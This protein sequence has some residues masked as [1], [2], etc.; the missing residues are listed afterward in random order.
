MKKYKYLQAFA[1]TFMHVAGHNW[2]SIDSE[3]IGVPTVYLSRIIP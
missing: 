1:W 2:K 3:N